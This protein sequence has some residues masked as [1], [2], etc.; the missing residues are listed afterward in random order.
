MSNTDSCEENEGPVNFS[1]KSTSTL[2]RPAGLIWRSPPESVQLSVA[3]S[4]IVDPSYERSRFFMFATNQHDEIRQLRGK[5]RS[6]QLFRQINIDCPCACRFRMKVASGICATVGCT[7]WNCQ[8][9]QRNINMLLK[10]PMIRHCENQ[11]SSFLKHAQV[12][13]FA[14]V[15]QE[16]KPTVGLRNVELSEM[17][18]KC[19]YFFG[20]DDDSRKCNWQLRGFWRRPSS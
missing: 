14:Q 17:F 5:Q 3:L 2:L 8:H 11:Q 1:D 19:G 6:R 12:H 13:A 15:S 9:L 18:T 20:G 7:F 4:W 10:I 16:I